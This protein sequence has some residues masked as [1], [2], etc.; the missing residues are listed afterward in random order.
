M[1]DALC[2]DVTRTSSVTGTPVADF[3]GAAP[4]CKNSPSTLYLIVKTTAIIPLIDN[5]FK[6]MLD[7]IHG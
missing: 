2:I 6:P 4:E 5:F 1:V 3:V 7:L